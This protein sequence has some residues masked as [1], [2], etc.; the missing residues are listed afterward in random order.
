VLAGNDD[1]AVV[2]I[3]QD[4]AFSKPVISFRTHGTHGRAPKALAPGH[5]FWRLR[6]TQRNVE[7]TTAS[8]A[9][10][11]FVPARSAPTD[12][13]WGTTLDL[14]GDGYAD[15]AA[16]AQ[17]V[18]LQQDAG[19]TFVYSGGPNGLGTTPVML[20]NQASWYGAFGVPGG[21]LDGDGYPELVVATQADAFMVYR[22]GPAWAISPAMIV[23][24]TKE[25]QSFGRTITSAGDIDG[26]GYGD[27]LVSYY[28]KSTQ[29]LATSI[30]YGSANGITG[31]QDLVSADAESH[32]SSAI[33]V[34]VNGDG[35]SDVVAA[36]G[37]RPQ[38]TSSVRSGSLEV[39]LNTPSGLSKTPSTIPLTGNVS[40]WV[41][42]IS[43]ASAGDVN[44]DGYADVLASSYEISPPQFRLYL[45]GPSGLSPNPIIIQ[46]GA[47]DENFGLTLTGAGD[48]DGDGYDEIVVGDRGPPQSLAY[49]YRGGPSGPSGTP[50]LTLQSPVAGGYFGNPV[51]GLGDVDGDGRADIAVGVDAGKGIYL[52]SGASSIVVPGVPP[53][54]P[55]FVPAP[56]TSW[57]FGE[58]LAGLAP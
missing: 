38:Q 58:T 39:F 55:L 34:D 13:S 29:E 36:L 2:D 1:A 52:F 17:I 50:W 11:L 33:A 46:G 41:F 32:I 23:N 22:G 47:T 15:L 49:V 57:S 7:G 30:F 18:D 54:T 14:D 3:A 8:A 40:S 27:L 16:G 44:G 10:E 45:G 42:T 4:R 53:T 35:L 19:A 28:V 9:W 21:D 25:Q 37:V 31:R 56:P 20:K 5:Y 12:T 24:A 48:V 6:G 43:L 26:D 51:A